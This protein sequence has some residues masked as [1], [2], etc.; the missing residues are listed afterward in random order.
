M[1]PSKRQ[2]RTTVNRESPLG[3][4]HQRA[5]FFAR[6]S[7][8]NVYRFIVAIAFVDDSGSG[9]DSPYYVL[10]GYAASPQV[11]DSFSEEW[12]RVLDLSPRLEYFKMNE[13]EGLKGQFDGF[14]REQRD[15]R[16]NAFIDV[17]LSH[18]L[19]EASLA[20]QEKDYRDILYPIL[21]G[22][23]ANPYYWPFIGMVTALSGLYRWSGSDEV[24][25][26]IFD[27]QNGQ[28]KQSLRL[29]EDFKV[30]YPLWRLGEVK[31]RSEAEFLP[32]QAA[33]LIA[34]QT[35]RFMCVPEG[36][37][38]TF[39]RLHSGR[40]RPYRKILKRRNLIEMAGAIEA[41]L[42]KMQ[43]LFGM[44]QIAKN[45]K[46]IENRNKREGIETPSFLINRGSRF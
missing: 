31:F 4:Y 23:Y 14:T 45:M 30:Q 21:P 13:A 22:K 12:K 44:E 7:I 16:L 38:A 24:V 18:G 40:V 35:R 19:F 6:E 39:K 5:F 2:E 34:W 10:A 42:S 43:K 46:K 32:L 29:Y 37:R 26:F 17:V 33:D 1:C 9:G 15:A 27:R 41:N 11:W 25:D 28:E 36:T 8:I 20:M 3:R